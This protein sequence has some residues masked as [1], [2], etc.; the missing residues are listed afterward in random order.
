MTRREKQ[1]LLEMKF[2][3]L[4]EEYLMLLDGYQKK[5]SMTERL[6]RTRNA[7]RVFLETLND[8]YRDETSAEEET[9]DVRS[10]WHLLVEQIRQKA[11]K[12]LEKEEEDGERED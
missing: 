4:V 11:E 1:D 7:A 5:E 9:A 2:K 10:A 6:L 8:I 12:N 3:T